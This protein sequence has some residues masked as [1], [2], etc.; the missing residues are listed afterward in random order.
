MSLKLNERYPSRFNNPSSDYPQGS[1]KN[2]T[3]PGAL[4]GSYLEQDWANDKEGFFQSLIATAGIVPSGDVDKVGASQY[5]DALLE[6]IRDNS[7]IDYLNT[8]RIDV[9]S[10]A[11]VNLSSGAPNTRHINITGT[12]TINGFTIAAG[13]CY[14]VRFA[15]A[16][17][18]TN[19]ATLVSNSGANIVTAA[20]D[21]CVLRATAANTVE[22]LCGRFRQDAATGTTGQTW[23]NVTAS[24]AANTNYTNTTGRAISVLIDR[25][26]SG[27]GANSHSFIVGGV[28][29]S[30]ISSSSQMLPATV[31]AV[32][33]N[34]SV[35][36]FETTGVAVIVNW[37]ELRN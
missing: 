27:S 33:P 22:I 10:A 23:Q 3:A 32:I 14:F 36:R 1:F 24:R 17:T 20:G 11:S 5:Y 25:G 35:Y 21:S 4:D 16:L 31:S 9:A 18:L 7:D 6:V 12:T 19:S 26:N 28:V 37:A 15:G 30:T 29:I 34:G 2:R 8:V 13:Q